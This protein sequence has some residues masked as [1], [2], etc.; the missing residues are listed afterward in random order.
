MDREDTVGIAGTLE[1]AVRC[2]IVAFDDSRHSYNLDR[3]TTLSPVA[4]LSVNIHDIIRGQE[5]AEHT[6]MPGGM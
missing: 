6:I 1:D 5:A 2:M 3:E 4:C